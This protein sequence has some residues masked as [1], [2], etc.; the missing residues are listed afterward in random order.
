FQQKDGVFNVV[1]GESLTTGVG[2]LLQIAVLKGLVRALGAMIERPTDFVKELNARILEM[3]QQDI[4]SFSLLTLYPARDRF[5]YISCGYTPL[6]YIPVGTETPRRL[7]ADNV[8]L[9]RSPNSD[10]LEVDANFNV[11]DTLLLHTF[12]AGSAKNV[13]E[14]EVEETQ[15]LTA[16]TE[17]LFLPPQ[18]Q[19]E[20]I[21]RQ[22]AQR[23]GPALLGRPITLIA[24]ER[25]M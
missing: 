9:G 11:G 15:F 6:W 1:M 21:F 17:N 4:F 12:Q 19:V 16:L 24:L 13:E 5:S 10:V 18:K 2:G 20:A 14:V 25:V 3:G 8:E 22:V 7:T 23:E